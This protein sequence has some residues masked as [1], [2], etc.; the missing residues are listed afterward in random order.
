MTPTQ[1][2]GPRKFPATVWTI[3]REAQG[4][5]SE[6]RKEAL[7]RLAQVYWR[8]VY[9]QLR[10]DWQASHWEAADLT[11]DYFSNLL[12]GSILGSAAQERGSFRA[13][14]KATLRHF[15]L[16]ARRNERTEKRGGGERLISIEELQAIETEPPSAGT[17]P[18]RAFERELMRS[19]V[20]NAMTELE[21][22]CARRGD[23]KLFEL[24]REFYMAEQAGERP[25]Y[26][27]L[28]ER[29]GLGPHEVKN[30]LADLRVRF[31]KRVLDLLRD[32]ISAE[33]ELVSEIQEVFGR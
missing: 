7:A 5:E 18:E 32:G 24:F 31:R 26:A 13:Y 12:T 3:I 30:K 6:P 4:M 29:F 25:S 1:D 8:P 9:W 10:Q 23:T 22:D 19:I 28:R 33:D 16:N 21:A 14:V 27:D 17:S 2:T 11:Q 20:R 15:V